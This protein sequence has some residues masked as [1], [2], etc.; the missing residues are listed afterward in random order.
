MAAGKAGTGIGAT[1]RKA[2]LDALAFSVNVTKASKAAG[3]T[4]AAIYRER[5]RDAKFRAQWQ[6]ALCEGYARLEAQLLA[7]A[8]VA[9]SPKTSDAMLKARQAKHR[10]GLALLAAHRVAVRGERTAAVPQYDDAADAKARLR[11]KLAEMDAN[12]G[13][14]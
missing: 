8:L 3:V 10:L 7:E 14:A 4:T 11:A 1:A 2:F 13:R 12:E 5:E 6:A 9:A